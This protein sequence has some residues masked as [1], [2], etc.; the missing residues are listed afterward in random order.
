M[1]HILFILCIAG[2]L[3][4]EIAT[5]Q[6]STNGNWTVV[7]DAGHGGKDP[8]ALGKRSKEKDIVLDVVLRVGKYLKNHDNI[9]V[10]YTRSTDVFVELDRRTKIANDAKADLFIS[11]HCN[12]NEKTSPNG[13]EVY[14]M[15]LNKTEANLAVAMKENS[16]ALLEENHEDR[17]DGI[18][19]NSTEAYIAFSL[20]QNIY[21]ERSLTMAQLI[22]KNLNNR[23]KLYDRGTKQAPFF[24]LYRTAMPSILIEAGFISN[25][26]DESVL[27]TD[28]GKEKI[29]YSIYNAIISYSNETENL[30]NIAVGMN[31]IEET[32]VQNETSMQSAGVVFKIQFASFK[33]IVP[34][35]DS[36]IKSLKNVSYSKAGTFYKYF[37]GETNSYN[38]ALNYLTEVRN[39]GYK[40]AFMVAFSNGASISVQDAR[41]MSGQ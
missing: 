37:C 35:S 36:R 8:G 19:P 30:G 4:S 7:L 22:M 15:G 23:L 13:T 32:V 40:D 38:E 17:Y 14:V 9:K 21:I 1:K 26:N 6:N 31:Q 39:S 28:A 25:Y 24:V 20:F 10:V 2:L 16:A 18:D 33:E 34:L 29:A 11:M 27:M 3:V 12:A 41:K 5:A